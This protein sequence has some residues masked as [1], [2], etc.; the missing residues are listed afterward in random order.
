[1]EEVNQ[2][3]QEELILENEVDEQVISMAELAKSRIE[4]FVGETNANV[5]FQSIPLK[6][7]EKKMIPKA[8]SHAQLEIK[9]DKQS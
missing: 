9:I 8:T 2:P 6:S 7:L 5:Q 4:L 3:P 1:M